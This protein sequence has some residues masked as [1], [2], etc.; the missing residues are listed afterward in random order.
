ML[1]E[2]KTT[3]STSHYSNKSQNHSDK[4][5]HT[6]NN[7]SSSNTVAADVNTPVKEQDDTD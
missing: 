6:H 1:Q 3:Q 2:F 4:Q 7:D 5:Q